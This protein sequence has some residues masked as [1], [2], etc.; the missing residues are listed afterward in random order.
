MTYFMW[1]GAEADTG[2]ELVV[3][4]ELVADWTRP[5]DIQELDE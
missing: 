4:D 1:L 3:P 2:D 5:L